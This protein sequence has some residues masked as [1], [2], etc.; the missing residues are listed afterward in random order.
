VRH[1][2]PGARLGHTPHVVRRE[3][4]TPLL[5]GRGAAWFVLVASW[6]DA[7]VKQ[8]RHAE[9]NLRAK[10]WLDRADEERTRAER[11]VDPMAKKERTEIAAR[12]RRLAQH[13]QERR[14]PRGQM[15]GNMHAC[16]S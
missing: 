3:V 14:S 5:S 2:L 13:A 8:V 1:K 10:Y 6:L 7:A 4:K 15:D 9:Q 11:M 12:Y 16:Q